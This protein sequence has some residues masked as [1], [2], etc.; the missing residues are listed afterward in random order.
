M[1]KRCGLKTG[2]ECIWND[3]MT[4]EEKTGLKIHAIFFPFYFLLLFQNVWSFRNFLM[5]QLK[6]KSINFLISLPVSCLSTNAQEEK[7]I[8]DTFLGS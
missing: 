6:G 1:Q 8:I 2:R 3:M 7:C 5:K 4:D